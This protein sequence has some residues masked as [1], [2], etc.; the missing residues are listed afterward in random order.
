MFVVPEGAKDE[1]SS[2]RLVCSVDALLLVPNMNTYPR[3]ATR[4]CDADDN[5]VVWYQQKAQG[6]LQLAQPC[7]L[8]VH[9]F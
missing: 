6:L 3:A 9:M 4:R 5:G 8:R 1:Y 7:Y 2:A